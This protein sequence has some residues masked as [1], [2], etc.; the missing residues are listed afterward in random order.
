[1][2]DLPPLTDAAL[3]ELR[4][5]LT[6]AAFSSEEAEAIGLI[7]EAH[8]DWDGK[9]DIEIGAEPEVSTV[10]IHIEGLPAPESIEPSQGKSLAEHVQ[11]GF[12]YRMH[13]EGSWRKVRLAHMSPARSFYVFT[14][15]AKHKRTISVTHRMLT[16][17]CETGRL[18][19]FENGYLLERATARARRQLAQIKPGPAQPKTA[20]NR[21]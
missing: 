14:S 18:R 19:A 2:A 12:A 7:D 21:R 11:I 5:A 13:L 4:D 16:R 20:P 15:G 6:P 8:V 3:P 17:L 1:V 9:V 10:D